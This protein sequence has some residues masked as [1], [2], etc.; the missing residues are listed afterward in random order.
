MAA[1][2]LTITTAIITLTN[3]LQRVISLLENFANAE[4]R[5]AEIKRDCVL[6]HSVLQYIGQQLASSREPPTLLIDSGGKHTSLL[7]AQIASPRKTAPRLI[8]SGGDSNGYMGFKNAQIAPSK[9]PPTLLID[10]GSADAGINLRNVLEDNVT[11]LQAD[12][13][14]LAHELEALSG[15]CSPET[16]IGRLIARGQITWKMSNLERMGQSIVSKRMQLELVLNS[17]KG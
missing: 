5:V 6:T 14:V 16:R 13:N 4:R 10:G 2:P 9:E 17:L 15:P 8:D 1:D 3:T 11:Q 7:N 12:L